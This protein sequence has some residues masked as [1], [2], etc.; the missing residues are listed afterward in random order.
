VSHTS[1]RARHPGRHAAASVRAPHAAVET[2][3]AAALRRLVEE[4][5][6]TAAALN[7]RDDLELAAASTQ[8]LGSLTSG[9][10][11]ALSRE[12]AT[13]ADRL[14][15]S[16]MD[17][18][19]DIDRRART[20]N[21]DADDVVAAGVAAGHL[22]EHRERLE[23]LVKAD[24][25]AHP[26]LAP[27]LLFGFSIENFAPEVPEVPADDESADIPDEDD[28]PIATSVRVV[29]F[30][31][32]AP[33]TPVVVTI[34]PSIPSGADPPLE[35]EDI[36][37]DLGVAAQAPLLEALAAVT[38]LSKDGVTQALSALGV[39]CWTAHHLD[40][41]SDD[42]DD[43]EE[44]ELDDDVEADSGPTGGG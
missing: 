31:W 8:R 37:L 32:Q 15:R 19:D 7:A 1:R 17:R 43:E 44:G 41:E 6:I 23:S 12:L 27:N 20:L 25:D 18:L 30:L 3:P 22:A 13:A 2:D 38:G 10:W 33:L 40:E 35:V 28:V 9:M 16:T 29:L 11:R 26:F 21:V 24:M 36:S 14:D 39:A 42:A 5:I 4:G 34:A